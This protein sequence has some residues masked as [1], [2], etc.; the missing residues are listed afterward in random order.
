MGPFTLAAETAAELM[1]DNPMSVRDS[2]SVREAVA[3]LIDKGISGAPVIDAAG[4]PVG[5]L[6][7]TDVLV[8]D[9]EKV[10]RVPFPEHETGSPLPREFW[11][12]FQIE[13]VDDVPV[14]DL[15]TPVVYSVP[16]TAPADLVIEQLVELP[17]HRLFVVDASGVLVGVVTARDVLRHLKP[18]GR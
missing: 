13:E 18:A 12:D 2:A 6:S 1:R 14:R 17:V 3:F 7:Q 10:D 9:R 11:N 15:M 16:A 4:R 8:H 5:V